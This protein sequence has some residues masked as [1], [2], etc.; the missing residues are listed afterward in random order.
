MPEGGFLWTVLRREGKQIP[1]TGSNS[2]SVHNEE[3]SCPALQYPAADTKISALCAF[4]PFK[5]QAV[6]S[7][8]LSKCLV[9]GPGLA[10]LRRSSSSHPQSIDGHL[11]PPNSASLLP[12]C[13]I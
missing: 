13:V 9:G 12:E 5:M 8:L 11:L 1:L 7:S 3:N 2:A 4:H 10:L 6:P